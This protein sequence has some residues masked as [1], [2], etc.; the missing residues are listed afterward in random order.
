MPSDPR[1]GALERARK[2]VATELLEEEEGRFGPADDA[3]VARAL[4]V[5]REV[6]DDDRLR[7]DTAAL[8]AAIDDKRLG[9][10]KVTSVRVPGDLHD[11]ASRVARSHGLTIQQ[12]VTTA[13]AEA[14]LRDLDI[15]TAFAFDTAGDVRAALHDARQD[16]SLAHELARIG[17]REP[18][19]A[20][21]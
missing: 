20:D 10:L 15:A 7:I 11:A 2:R 13:L 8:D 18:D 12:W 14:L 1:T 5:L 17:E 4:E 21:R 19:L 3:L 16:G 6:L 9:P